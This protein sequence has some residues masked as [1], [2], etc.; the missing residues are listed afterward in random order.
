MRKSKNI[1]DDLKKEILSTG[2]G[3]PQS[4]VIPKHNISGAAPKF[5]GYRTDWAGST[6]QC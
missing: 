3:V 6:D 5:A 4:V 1:W 2:Y